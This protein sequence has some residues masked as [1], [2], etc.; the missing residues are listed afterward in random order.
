VIYFKEFCHQVLSEL[1][2][3]AFQNSEKHEI[4]ENFAR[5]ILQLEQKIGKLHEFMQKEEKKFHEKF[6]DKFELIEDMEVEVAQMK[7][8]CEE[9]IE[10][11]M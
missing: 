4:I 6:D 10:K 7:I 8:E 9:N 1:S 5:N 11:I 2:E 3:T